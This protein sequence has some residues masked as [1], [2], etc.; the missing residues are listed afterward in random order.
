MILNTDADI[1]EYTLL[2]LMIGWGVAVG[3]VI[4]VIGVGVGRMVI[5]VGVGRYAT[6]VG[7]G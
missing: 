3:I 5:G 7:V 2:K 1:F 4:M 6:T